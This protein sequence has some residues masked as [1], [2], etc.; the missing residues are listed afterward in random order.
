VT[1]ADVIEPESGGGARNR[2]QQSD[3]GSTYS[4]ESYLSALSDALRDLRR[5]CPELGYGND[6]VL[7]AEWA[8]ITGLS[9]TLPVGL[10]WKPALIH[11]VCATLLEENMATERAQSQAAYHRKMYEKEFAGA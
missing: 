1:A 2:L 5:N 8:E 10:E 11:A 6:G 4:P 7:S 9:Q 3:G